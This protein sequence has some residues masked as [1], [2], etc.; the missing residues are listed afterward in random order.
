MIVKCNGAMTEFS[1]SPREKREGLIRDYVL[2]LVGLLHERL[3][4][5]VKA[6][7]IAPES[8]ERC[9]QL[10]KRIR[11]EESEIHQINLE[12]ILTPQRINESGRVL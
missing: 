3:R 7:G 12:L 9:R 2:E 8:A 1:P 4:L 6:S 5:I 11:T 10:P